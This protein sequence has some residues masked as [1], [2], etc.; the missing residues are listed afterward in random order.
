MRALSC[1]VLLAFSALRLHAQDDRPTPPDTTPGRGLLNLGIHHTGISF[2]N[3]AR[4]TGLRINFRDRGVE[5]IDG[6][7]LTLWKAAKDANRQAVVNGLSIGLVG[8]EAG[9]LN[10]INLGLVGSL[11]YRH[12]AGIN[13]GGFG[14]VSDGRIT[15]INVG[16]LGVVSDGPTS[17]I[18]VAGLG[19]VADGGVAG[20]TLAGLGVV[21]DGGVRGFAASGLGTVADGGIV[22]VG[23]GGLATV[24]DKGITGVG[25]GGLAVVADG[26][27]HGIGI[28]GLAVVADR[29][30]TGLGIGGL[31]VV[32][33]DRISGASFSLGEINAARITGISATAYR[34]RIRESGL[35]WL[36]AGWIKARETTGFQIAAYN[37]V[38]GAQH[39]LAIGVFNS[40]AELHG[41]QI[42]LLNRAGNN[43]PPFRWLP[44]LDVHH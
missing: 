21:A 2:G 31:A 8:P 29:N 23:I 34:I 15:G 27:I 10:G 38:L 28:G 22:G 30:I 36:V 14:L 39:G 7:N 18:N 6:I 41:M 33:D 4:W 19:V 9:Q 25:I 26:G 43:R 20:I 37:Q 1:V 40:A 5:R 12:S 13:I 35:G 24:A 16:G 3:S 42:G 11:S 32:A 17:G 44:I